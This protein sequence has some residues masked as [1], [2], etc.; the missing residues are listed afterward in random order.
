MHQR[1]WSQRLCHVGKMEDNDEFGYSGSCVSRHFSKKFGP[2]HRSW[3]GAGGTQRRQSRHL[4]WT[5][6]GFPRRNGIPAK[7]FAIIA[8]DEDELQISM[9][10][11]SHSG[12]HHDRGG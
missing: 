1:S 10:R 12:R 11:M 5:L 7:Q 2:A 8:D 6:W 3:I 9:A 4:I